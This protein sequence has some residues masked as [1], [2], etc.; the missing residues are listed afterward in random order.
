MFIALKINCCQLQAPDSS[1]MVMIF[2]EIK[3]EGA[4]FLC[5]FPFMYPHAHILKA[6]TCPLFF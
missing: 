6:N 1:K 3:Q 5:L 2:S 4:P